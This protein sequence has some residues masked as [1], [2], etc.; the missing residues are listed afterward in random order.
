AL[1][2]AGVHH[3]VFETCRSEADVYPGWARPESCCGL[4]SVVSARA[5]GVS[6]K[7][8]SRAL[9]DASFARRIDCADTRAG[10]P[11]SAFSRLGTFER[12]TGVRALDHDALV[13]HRRWEAT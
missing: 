5:G 6:E 2:R 8:L 3:V 13:S 9:E 10:Y 11:A 7:L 1:F 4:R 12:V